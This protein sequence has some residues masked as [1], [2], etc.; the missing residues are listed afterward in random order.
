MHESFRTYGLNIS[1][2]LGNN[3][4]CFDFLGDSEISACCQSLYDHIS[5]KNEEFVSYYIFLHCIS[6][7]LCTLALI[8]WKHWELSLLTREWAEL[9][10]NWFG[11]P[12]FSNTFTRF[13]MSFDGGKC[14]PD[15]SKLQHIYFVSS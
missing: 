2:Y 6:C 4:T 12:D 11:L 13:I 15:A 14:F 3:F 5:N 9:E 1:L 10:R 7:I 8:V